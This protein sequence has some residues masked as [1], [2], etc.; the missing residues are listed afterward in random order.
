MDTRFPP[1][2][3]I[4]FYREEHSDLQG[5]DDEQLLRHYE[6]YGRSEGRAANSLR[7]RGD[8]AKL[9]IEF[10]RVL[11]IGPFVSPVLSGPNVSYADF[12]S[13]E[14]LKARAELMG[15]EH[16]DVPRIHY[17]LSERD[18]SDIDAQ[19]DCA[20]SSHCIEHQ[21]NLVSHLNDVAK[22][23]VGK[24]TKY[25]LLI[26]DKRYCFDRFMPETTIADVIDAHFRQPKVHSLKSVIEHRALM[27]HNDASAHWNERDLVRGEIDRERVMNAIS[28][29]KQ[30]E[31]KYVD[32]HAWYFTP[33]SFSEI[34]GILNDIGLI[35]FRID[36][37][38]HTRRGSNEFWAILGKN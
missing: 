1:P 19:F 2:L 23:L 8:F 16:K 33:D 31:G 36:V 28:E 32:V 17:I 14:E 38:Y 3:D 12:L 10:D 18:L 11:E 7:T 34:V 4:V 24:R 15:I 30:A 20:I 6:L 22:I 25:F 37:L 9:A 29:W 13:S 35:E 26:P 27:A 21:P 5:L